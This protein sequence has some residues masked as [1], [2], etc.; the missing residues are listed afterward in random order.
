LPDDPPSL[1]WDSTAQIYMDGIFDDGTTW[2]ERQFLTTPNQTVTVTLTFQL[3]SP[4]Q[5]SV[6]AW[7]VV[8]I[9][10]KTAPE[11]EVDFDIIGYT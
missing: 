8:A 5:A 6:G 9:A 4:G 10:D 3:W 7:A 11:N 1:T 2:I